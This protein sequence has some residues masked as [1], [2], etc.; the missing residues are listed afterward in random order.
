MAAQARGEVALADGDAEAALAALRH[1]CQAWQELDAPHE[2]ARARALLGVTYRALGDEDAATYELE[3][4]RG[5]FCG[6]RRGAGARLGGLAHPSARARRT[7]EHALTARELEVLRLVATGNSNREIAATL[8]ISERTV[9]RHLQ[10]I[11]AKLRVSS[12]TA[13]SA[14]AFEHDLV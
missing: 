6:A 4:A 5:V 3:A 2:S 9:A 7:A 11:F 1:A 10:N 12:R 8:F 13:A 14:F